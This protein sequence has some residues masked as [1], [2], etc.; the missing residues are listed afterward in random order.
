LGKLVAQ[1]YRLIGRLGEGSMADVYLARHVLIDRLSAIKLLRPEFGG[2]EGLRRRFLQEA[3]AV[4]RINHPNIVEITDYGE[5]EGTAYLVMEYVP[6]EPLSRHLAEGPLGFERALSAGLQIASAL[7]RAHEMGV[8]HRDLTPAN[9]LVVPRRN[10]TDLVK[11]TDF[12]VAKM[13]HH[14]AVGPGVTYTGPSDARLDP[15]YVAPE[16]LTLG[17]VDGRSDLYS[18]GVLLYHA[19]S[20]EPPSRWEAGRSSAP[21]SPRLSERADVPRRFDEIV[22]TLMAIDPDDRPRDAFETFEMLRGVAEETDAPVSRS[23]MA[24]LSRP[25]DPKPKKARPHLLTVSFERIGPICC[26][27]WA[28]LARVAGVVE[29]EG[30]LPAHLDRAARGLLEAAQRLVRMVEGLA[31]IVEGDARALAAAEGRGRTFR[32]SLGASLDEVAKERSRSLGWAGTIAE[33][34]DYVRAQRASGA[35]P[36]PTT[37]A[38]L[39]E[40]A[41]LEQEEE[42]AYAEVERL[43]AQFVDLSRKLEQANEGLEHEI[44]VLSA[45]LD[46]HI[47]ALRSLAMEAWLAL[48]GAASALDVDLGG[49]L[50]LADAPQGLE[51]APRA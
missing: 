11:L 18:L 40:Q 31:R 19:T 23:S 36:I 30:V 20:G 51:A 41:A 35:H 47:A 39:W 33:R 15:A 50:D 46:G 32:A 1:R 17:T 43:S 26:A 25:S 42:R 2:D 12:G 45:Q 13:T 8:I 38:M 34:R 49:V 9:V 22:A 10:A 24:S 28:E 44:E 14:T 27:A 29:P 48:E 7:S 37:D 3:K 4:N 6:G 21:P 16:V 5:T